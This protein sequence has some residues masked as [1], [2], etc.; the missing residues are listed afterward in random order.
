MTRVTVVEEK[1]RLTHVALSGRLDLQ[2]VMQI[3][4]EFNQKTVSPR[5]SAIVD[6]SAVNVIASMGIGMLIEAARALK[7]AGAVLVLVAPSDLVNRTLRQT[8]VNTIIP[9]VSTVEEANWEA[10]GE[11]KSQC[12]VGV[13]EIRNDKVLNVWYFAA[14][15]CSPAG[16]E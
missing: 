7:D 16:T 13:Y 2:G 9:I 10:D 11:R 8:H 15:A 6:L 1:D 3:Q 4:A 5:R 14:H 12:S